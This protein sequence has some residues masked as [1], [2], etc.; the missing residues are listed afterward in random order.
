MRGTIAPTTVD[1]EVAE[2][3]SR[4][5]GKPF[6]ITIDRMEPERLFSFRWHP[7][8]RRRRRRLLGRADDARRLRA[9]GRSTGGTSLTVTE[10]RLRQYPARAP[11]PGLRANE[12]GWG[13]AGQAHRQ[14]CCPASV[15]ENAALGGVRARLRSAGR[16]D[17]PAARLAPVR[18][19]AACRSPRL[20]AGSEV[21]RQAITKHLQVLADAGLA[22]SAREGRERV[23]ELEPRRLAACAATSSRSR[24]SGTTPSAA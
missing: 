6:E 11:R 23:W 19:R 24:S 8:R 4:Y 5:A 9:R 22:R 7:V 14:V 18:G 12:Q 17:A 3:R 1:A 16:R 13:M 15:S 10:S 2:R 20:A 21:T